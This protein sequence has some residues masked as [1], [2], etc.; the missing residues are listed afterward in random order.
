MSAQHPILAS[1][2]GLAE[3]LGSPLPPKWHHR[4]YR[5]AKPHPGV[6]VL[7]RAADQRVVPGKDR[8]NMPKDDAHNAF[9]TFITIPL[10]TVAGIAIGEL[11]RRKFKSSAG[12]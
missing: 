7:A 4:L 2:P 3:A 5:R 10:T 9:W 12:P 6:A 8:P 11:I 1:S